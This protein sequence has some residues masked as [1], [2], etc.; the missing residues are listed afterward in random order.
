M[1]DME[2]SKA[3]QSDTGNVRE[4]RPSGDTQLIII[5]VAYLKMRKKAYKNWS[6]TEE[7]KQKKKAAH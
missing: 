5:T 3:V 4:T 1:V 2:L 6:E 7:N